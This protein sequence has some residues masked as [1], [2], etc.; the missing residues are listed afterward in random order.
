MLQSH[1]GNDHITLSAF[2]SSAFSI[3]AGVV[4]FME[5]WLAHVSHIF[6]SLAFPFKTNKLLEST[7]FKWRAHSIELIIILT[8]G[9][10]PAIVVAS[11]S[12]YEFDGFTSVCAP[13]SQDVM[14]YLVVLPIAIGAATGICLLLVSVWIIHKVCQ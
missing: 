9:L 2:S 7:T 12:G 4:T 5:F 3:H 8:I 6:L 11:T 13:S 10:L 14:F 1:V